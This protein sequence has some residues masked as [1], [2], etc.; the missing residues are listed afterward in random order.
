M[1]Y[2]FDYWSQAYKA[3]TTQSQLRLR[4]AECYTSNQ[5]QNWTCFDLV[6]DGILQR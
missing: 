5:M 6:L 2:H 3:P 4:I 1:Y